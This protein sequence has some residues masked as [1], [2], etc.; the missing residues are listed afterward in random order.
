MGAGLIRFGRLMSD[1]ISIR[2]FT[3]LLDQRGYPYIPERGLD[4]AITIRGGKRPNS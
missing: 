2:R 3:W 4:Q 1:D